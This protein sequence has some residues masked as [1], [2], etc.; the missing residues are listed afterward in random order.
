MILEL[1]DLG[2]IG[3]AASSH[4]DNPCI[5]NF[6]EEEFA[7]LR[8]MYSYPGIMIIHKIPCWRIFLSTVVLSIS[9]AEN[10]SPV[11]N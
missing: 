7:S 2:L 8:C 6:R 3:L 11:T 5:D 4:E 1:E 10:L 9:E